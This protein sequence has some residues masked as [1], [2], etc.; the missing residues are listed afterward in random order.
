MLKQK[1][2]EYLRGA[3][4]YLSGQE[5]S[6]RCGVSRTAVWKAVESL[7]Q[8]GYIIDSVTRR[9]YRLVQATPALCSVEL[10]A[11][12]PADFPWRDRIQV[13]DCVDSTNTVAKRLA[14]QGAPAGTTIVADHQTGGRG[15]L[16]RSFQSPAGLGTYL[17]II[18][19]PN[20]KPEQLMTL[21]AMIAEAVC[22]AVEQA[23][24]LRPQI[25]WANDLL[26]QK[27]KICGILTELSVEAES[28]LVQYAVVGIGMNCNQRPEDFPPELQKT[29]ISLSMALG[30]TV[31][32]NLVAAA[33]I[34]SLCNL[35][36]HL[37]DDG[38]WPWLEQYT[39]DCITIGKDVRIIQG[40]QARVGHAVG[41]NEQAALLVAYPDGTEEAVSC[42]EVSVRGI[43][44][45]V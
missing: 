16:G 43:Y 39:H 10:L 36:Q 19:R 18:L 32:R 15:R 12:L 34:A 7:R 35:A 24:Q 27:R 28:G 11:A 13:F 25:K 22:E 33:Q 37:P 44:G 8:D 20:A 3:N 1:V 42:G 23:C 26:F 29:A 5:I 9:G 30:H 40:A 14:A 41:L 6:H 31:N 38:Q 17:S 4:G 2:L 21:T 45:Y